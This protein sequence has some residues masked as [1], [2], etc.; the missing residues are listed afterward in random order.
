MKRNK[1]RG[2]LIGVVLLFFGV[3]QSSAQTVVQGVVTDAVSNQPLQYVSV[4]FK[5]GRGTVTDSLGKYTLRSSG[6]N[7]IILVTYV[8]YKTITK[9][10]TAGTT[11][12]LDLAMET[13]PKAVYNVT[14]TTKK[15]AP[16]HN[17]N[18]PAVDLIRRVIQNK[19][20]NR[21]ERYNYLQYDQYEKMEVSVSNVNNKLANSKLLKNYKFLLENSDTTKVE[22][23]ALIPVYLEE[24]LSKKYFR[25][26]PEKTK[27]I[28]TGQKQVDFGEYIDNNGVKQYLNRLVMDIDIYD[29]DIP[30]FTYQ[31]L[32][33]IADLAPTFYMYYIRDT[34]TQPDG[35]KLIKL[36][37]TPRTTGDLLFRGNMYITL[38]GN[39]SIQKINMFLSKNVN[40][41]FVRDLHIDLDFEK[42]E[43][44]RYHLSRSNVMADAAITK[45]SETG[46]YGERTVSYKNFQ[47]NKPLPDSVYEGP[48]LVKQDKAETHNDNYW[49]QN[50]HDSLTKTEAKVYS[51]IDSLEKMPSFR[52]TM[53]I[54]TLLLAGYTSLGPVEIGPAAAFYSFNPVEGF[55]LRLG[56][57]T[58]PK[59][60]KRIY[61]EGY[62]AYGFE[63]EKWKYFISS[64]YSI[65]NK[66]I[67]EYPLKYIK[68]GYQHD[69]K[70]PGQELQFVSE[71]N[72]LLSFK[73]GI[74]DKWLYNSN[75]KVDYVH[76]L[77]NH[78]SYTLGFKNWKQQPAG[79]LEYN[80]V[81]NGVPVSVENIITSEFSTELRWAPHEQ[82][83]QGKVYRIPIINK[84]PIFTFRFI[85]GVKGIWNSGYNYQN[86]SARMEKRMYMSQLGYSDIVAEAGYIFGN[87]IPYPLL[88]IHRANQTYAY[89]LNSYNLMNFQEFVSDHYASV[90]LDHHFNGLFFNRVPLLKK[91]NLREVFSVKALW[92]GIREENDPTKNPSLIQF[93]QTAGETTS[94]SLGKEPYIEGSVGITNIFKLIR[95]DYIKRFTYLNHPYVASQGIRVR[96]KF[97]F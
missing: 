74:N 94:F 60:S 87:Q 38:D 91:L 77:A 50:R 32:S 37:F 51:N 18:N 5:G 1:G 92:G 66:S 33:P 86:L 28:V 24:T 23:K 64:T 13:D 36:Y 79:S 40:L 82:F 78:F 84:Y 56:G 10:I 42:S 75:F 58:T 14:V 6:N 57:R 61:F 90:S 55:K 46:F 70:I 71:D 29:N 43:D 4:V 9:T 97:D 19:P 27:T 16:Y 48:A 93:P 89:Q 31:F 62:G 22:G 20:L 15:K 96:F 3:L 68:V 65:N 12:T 88:T 67:Y 76:E 11:Q 85:G 45:S 34:I 95:V 73:R 52:R 17:K 81:D 7:A 41:N 44:N 35:Q 69:T 8:G 83:Y 47:I 30:L 53:A 26:K 72:F 80:K 39:Y 21:A 63:D 25:K 59:L 2:L 49:V 54:A